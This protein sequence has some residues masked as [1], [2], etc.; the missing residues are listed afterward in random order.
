[1]K[2]LLALFALL[3]LA[4]GAA[5]PA[6]LAELEA[7]FHSVKD[8]HALWFNAKSRGVSIALTGEA[9]PDL[10]ARY[11]AERS[12]LAAGLGGE[13][14]E[15]ALDD[16]DRLALAQM[17]EALELLPLELAAAGDADAASCR[18][19]VADSFSAQSAWMYGCFS[20][21]ASSLA[22]EGE[23]LDRLGLMA[24][25]A[26]EPDPQRRQAL[27]LAMQPLWTAVNG[28]NGTDSPYRR[29]IRLRAAELADTGESPGAEVRG[30]GVDPAQM[31]DWLLQA[32][33][34][35]REGLPEPA[36]PPW[37]LYWLG[38]AAGRALDA[39]LPAE[40][41]LVVNHAYYR[42]LGA[43]PAAL[44][45]TYDLEQRPGKTPVAFVYNARAAGYRANGH[46]NHGEPWV[47]ATYTEGGLDN[48][49]EL[50]H[51]TGHAVHFAAIR[52]RPALADWPASDLFT[53]GV[54]EMA[55]LE[56]FDPAWQQRYLG[57][58]ADPADNRAARFRWQVMDMAWA[59]FE[60]RMLRTPDADPNAEWTALTTQYLNVAPQ[61]EHAWW[62]VR[63]QLVDWPGY[64]MNY[65][66]GAIMVADLRQRARERWGD[67]IALRGDWYRRVGETV[68]RHGRARP[69]AQVLED[70]LGRPVSPQAFLDELRAAP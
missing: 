32:L 56:I 13:A 24:R 10:V 35:W 49:Y 64:M 26:R 15:A 40:R 46:W 37:D 52:G 6:W 51:E 58:V 18:P 42:D 61:Q 2:R 33:A 30:I 62:A 28:D 41:L 16:A 31:E 22:F 17:R 57:M 44:D 19:A 14:L 3:P 47:F 53:E 7:R 69:A 21:A 50:L 45:V 68:F 4:A 54:A 23:T 36:V 70:F 39:A 55:A 38:G 5:S 67:D 29:L 25:L 59:L 43:D 8:R 63:G 60:L 34:A 66:A 9:L 11:A 12:V 20:A 1:M 65:A 48:L 27:W